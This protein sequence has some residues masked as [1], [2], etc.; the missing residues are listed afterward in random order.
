M[1]SGKRHI[2]E[3]VQLPNQEVIRTLGEKETY[4]YLGILEAD[5][6]KQQE[7]KERKKKNSISEEPENYSRQNSIARTLSKGQIP[8]LSLSWDTRD[9]SW[10]GPENNLNK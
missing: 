10:S 5:T 4:K 3:G 2:T 8:G 9:H 6:I 7:M 1:K